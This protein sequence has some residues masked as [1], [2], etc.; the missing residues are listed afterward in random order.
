LKCNILGGKMSSD[1]QNLL[2]LEQANHL[3]EWLEYST[4]AFNFGISTVGASNVT[5][6]IESIEFA[7]RLAG[8]LGALVGGLMGATTGGLKGAVE[9]AT[10]SLG[11]WAVAELTFDATAPFF[12]AGGGLP[13]VAFAAVISAGAGLFTSWGLGGI[14]HILDDWALEAEIEAKNVPNPFDP[15]WSHYYAYIAPGAYFTNDGNIGAGGVRP[16]ANPNYEYFGTHRGFDSP[17]EHAPMSMRHQ[18]NPETGRPVSPISYHPGDHTSAGDV[19]SPRDHTSASDVEHSSGSNPSSYGVSPGNQSPGSSGGPSGTPGSPGSTGSH[20]AGHTPGGVPSPGSTG[21]HGGGH[22]PSGGP[23]ST[24]GSPY[25]PGSTGGN[26][27]SN[28][29]S[30]GGGYHGGPNAGGNA[31]GMQTGGGGNGGN[32]GPGNG[33]SDHGIAGT[34]GNGGYGCTCSPVLLDLEGNGFDVDPLSSSSF[35]ADLNGDGQQSRMAWAGKGTGVL[36]FD[37]DGD[38]RISQEKEFAFTKWDANA[39]SDLEAIKNVFDTN[40]NGKLDAGDARFGEFK[41]WVNG[42]LV[43]LASLGITSIDL[44]PS[45]SGQTFADG[46]AI[47]GTA[48]YTK[49]DGTAGDTLAFVQKGDTSA[50]GGGGRLGRSTSKHLEANANRQRALTIANSDAGG[51][52]ASRS[53]WDIAHRTRILRQSEVAA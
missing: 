18:P 53:G 25:G 12:G 9:E 50:N 16:G 47:A 49:M 19:D 5:H 41:V 24:P 4:D 35:F 39:K 38:G 37:A 21:S 48:S 14:F 36:V 1:T 11:G 33:F 31:G 46:S 2:E 43:T 30:G 6:A 27:G 40:H 28:T 52:L 10:K 3:R 13:G 29:P 7:S 45:G 15:N 42:N 20:G 32:N 44:T 17:S 34:Q 26:G 51:P 23:N 8:P 22:T